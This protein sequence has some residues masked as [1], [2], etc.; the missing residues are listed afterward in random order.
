M[1]VV[2]LARQIGLKRLV[3]LKVITTASAGGREVRARFRR[4]AEAVGRLQHPSIVSVYEVGEHEGQPFLALEYVRGGSLDRRLNGL[5]LPPRDAAALVQTIAR[6]VHAAHQAGVVH[7]DLKPAN[8]LIEMGS[9]EW[10]MGN[11]EQGNSSFSILH[12]PL[13]I[14]KVAD[15]GLAKQLNEDTL[16]TRTG[17]I[18]GT[19]AY[20]A[21]EQ[22]SGDVQQI[23][24]ACDIWALGA[25]LYELLTGRPPFR[26]A[27]VL[28]TL[29][30]VR[31]QEPVAPSWLQA[32]VPRD[33]DTICLKCLQ[34]EM[35][36][37]Y[38]SAEALADDLGRF[39]AGEPIVAR[40]VGAAERLVKWARRRPAVAALGALSLL[41][42]V[43]GFTLV[44]LKWREALDAA[45]AEQQARSAE[46]E[47][48]RQA[49]QNATAALKA[50]HIAE[51]AQE[52]AEFNLYRSWV[53]LAER[54]WV[55]GNVVAARHALDRCRAD[56]RGW[57][58]D[59]LR[60][61]HAGS[62]LTLPGH[63]YA[64]ECVAFSPDGRTLVSGG[65]D[66]KVRFWDA[67]TGKA[68]ASTATLVG[69]AHGLR[70][71]PDGTRLVGSDAL[72]LYAWDAKTGKVVSHCQVLGLSPWTVLRPDGTQ[73]ASPS[74]LGVIQLYDARTGQE[75][76]ALHGHMGLVNTLAYSADGKLLASAGAD[77]TVRVWAPPAEKPLL[78]LRDAKG[79]VSAL[80]FSAD[81]KYLAA[82]A[83]RAI[84]VWEAQT[85]NQVGTWET[86]KDV[87]AIAFAPGG[88]LATA[89]GDEIKFWEAPGGTLLRALRG[90][91]R[92]VMGLAFSPD[93]AR[94]ASAAEAV[95]VWDARVAADGRSLPMGKGGVWS[96]SFSPDGRRLVAAADHKPPATPGGIKVWDV[97]TRQALLTFT[98]HPGSSWGVAF[99][100]TGN[101]IASAGEDGIVRLWDATTG[102]VR[103]E[104][105]GHDAKV[106]PLAFSPDGRL[107]ASG[108]KDA[109][110]RLWDADTGVEL[111]VLRKHP[112]E[113]VSLAFSRDGKL[114]GSGGF[115]GAVEIWDA[116][117]GKHLRSLIGSLQGGRGLSFHPD[118]KR[119]ASSSGLVINL[120]DVEQ[121][122]QE[123]TMRTPEDFPQCTAFNPRGDRLAVGGL[124]LR[125]W[126]PEHGEETLALREGHKGNV[127]SVAFSPDGRRLACGLAGGSVLVREAPPDDGPLVYRGHG[128]YAPAVA[129]FGDG[130]TIISGGYDQAV[131]LWDTATL[132]DR[133]VLRSSG[134]MVC[135]VAAFPDGRRIAA[136]GADGFVRIWD[137]ESGEVLQSLEGAAGTTQALAISP[138]SKL[139]AFA[140][141]D[142]K[143]P[144]R[145]G[146]VHV[147]TDDGIRVYALQGHKRPVNALPFSPDGRQ[148]ASAGADGSVRTWGA[149]D[150]SPLL[151]LRGPPKGVSALAFSPD[152][153]LLAA[154]GAADAEVY[155]WSSQD[156][157]PAGRLAANEGGVGGIAFHPDGRHLATVGA[158]QGIE[159]WDV[160]AR[161]RVHAIEG[162]KGSQVTFSADGRF[163]VVAGDSEETVTVWQVARLLNDARA[164]SH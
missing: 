9:G 123:L 151:E 147:Y 93:G 92:P 25:I 36:R 11:E 144:G 99:R 77:G 76:T 118:G 133:R 120:W 117:T 132:R 94:L 84:C 113:V 122:R 57:E 20:M 80:A 48:K 66:H 100:P 162:H 61:V 137:R 34:K 131:R 81:G 68:G 46:E 112:S 149:Q 115:Q 42:F 52:N 62:L 121:G 135:A 15:F 134:S 106:R 138:D 37:R 125:L 159:L 17:A 33:L 126:E 145:P 111:H 29:E 58:W 71:T 142:P 44:T 127:L 83:Y 164:P 13:P 12:S 39:L 2:Y 157:K 51:A 72:N 96:L 38:V 91:E 143:A 107:L 86:A 28:D 163:L 41:L 114:L 54:E 73:A 27:S 102:K 74:A 47:Q 75:T 155:L 55:A 108:G 141:G 49:L 23:G 16:Q 116:T 67:A 158:R 35:A 78:T 6:A 103:K 8:I 154:A 59:Y 85:G 63:L 3:A 7:R 69:A 156:G 110:V 136:A 148:L 88:E 89:D 31:S 150:G 18:L 14:A 26:A 43:T 70:F 160:S 90:H 65:A 109:T 128:H 140:G 119:L 130:R 19:P 60:H 129:F 21:P 79:R 153:G 152:N 53:A 4:E 1:G 97:T 5:P 101:E 105:R 161:R 98:E 50:Q 146:T 56:L 32:K 95:K 24:P 139:I 104:L 87:R 124:K 30:Q 40:P 45:Q 64:V 82:G 22:A 10:R